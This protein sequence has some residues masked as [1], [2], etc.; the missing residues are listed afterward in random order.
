[1]T[2]TQFLSFKPSLPPQSAINKEQ[3]S[4]GKLVNTVTETTLSYLEQSGL[5]EFA[6]TDFHL[7]L[8]SEKHLKA[9]FNPAPAK[10]MW[11]PQPTAKPSLSPK[12]LPTPIPF[13]H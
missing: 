7:C 11:T 6:L 5:Q 10:G 9:G 2:C 13:Y 3:L 12:V 1:M 8:G 4:R